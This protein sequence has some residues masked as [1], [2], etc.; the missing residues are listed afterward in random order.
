MS[1][2]EFYFCYFLVRITISKI[3]TKRKWSKHA[4]LFLDCVQFNVTENKTNWR[5]CILILFKKEKKKRNRFPLHFYIKEER[6]YKSLIIK[7]FI[8]TDS[9]YFRFKCVRTK[10][11]HSSCDKKY[12]L[13]SRTHLY[14]YNK[15]LL[16]NFNY[17]FY[18]KCL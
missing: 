5:P 2:W 3:L 16:N 18:E 8:N 13:K 17:L 9:F 15:R 14:Y 12:L 1:Y 6:D 11:S 7:L 10:Q 4:I